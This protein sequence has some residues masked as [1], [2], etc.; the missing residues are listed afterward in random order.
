LSVTKRFGVGVTSSVRASRIAL[1]LRVASL[2]R[3]GIY[4]EQLGQRFAAWHRFAELA[5]NPSAF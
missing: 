1:G 5:Q 4:R 2:V 3:P